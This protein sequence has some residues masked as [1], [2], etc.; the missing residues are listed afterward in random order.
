MSVETVEIKT[1]QMRKSKAIC[2]EGAT[3]GSRPSALAFLQGLKRR[4]RMGWL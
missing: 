3:V 1:K 4:Q 2:A